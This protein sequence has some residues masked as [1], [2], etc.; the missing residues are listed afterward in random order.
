MIAGY[1][2][3]AVLMFSDG[4]PPMFIPPQEMASKRQCELTAADWRNTRP[5]FSHLTNKPI[6]RLYADCHVMTI[7]L[8]KHYFQ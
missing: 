6:D 3:V 5:D 7:D 8:R 1:V 4:T 2:L